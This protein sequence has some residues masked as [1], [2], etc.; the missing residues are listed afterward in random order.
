VQAPVPVPVPVLVPGLALV[1]ALHRI[2]VQPLVV[3]MRTAE[4]E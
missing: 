1:R 3:R 2:R 4:S